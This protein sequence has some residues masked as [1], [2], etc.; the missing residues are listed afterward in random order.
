MEA[1]FPGAEVLSSTLEMKYLWDFPMVQSN[2]QLESK[3]WEEGSKM[4]T[5]RSY[6]IK[7]VSLFQAVC[8]EQEE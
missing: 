7:M 3:R 5:R 2:R 1:R 6:I 4:E 8:V